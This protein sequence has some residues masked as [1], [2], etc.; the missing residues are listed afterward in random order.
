MEDRESVNGGRYDWARV[1]RERIMKIW[2]GEDCI[3]VGLLDIFWF[4][5]FGFGV[6]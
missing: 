1:L 4:W 5:E 6:W 3:S 2:G